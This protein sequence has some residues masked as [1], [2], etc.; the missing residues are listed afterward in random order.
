VSEC[1]LEVD[2]ADSFIDG[3]SFD[4]REHRRV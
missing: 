2:E 3:K 1:R 4:L